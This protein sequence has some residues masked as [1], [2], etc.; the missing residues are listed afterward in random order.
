MTN[1]GSTATN[2]RQSSRSVKRNRVSRLCPI[3]ARE[4]PTRPSPR[5][6]HEFIIENFADAILNGTDLI[7]PAEE[8]L[9]SVAINNAIILS[10]QKRQMVELPPDGAEVAALLEKYIAEPP[11]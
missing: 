5:H 2:G 3:R 6:G 7:A 8:G 1:C 9:H 10:A 11:A 4:L